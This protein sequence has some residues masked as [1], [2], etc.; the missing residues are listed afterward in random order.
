MQLGLAV[1]P[2]IQHRTLPKIS[3]IVGTVSVHQSSHELV[4]LSHSLHE[5]VD[6]QL[7]G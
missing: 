6:S 3:G 7:A 1:Y 4:G 5:S 2:Q